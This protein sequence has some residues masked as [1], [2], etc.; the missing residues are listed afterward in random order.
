MKILRMGD[1]HIKPNN[2]EESEA[3]L[4]FVLNQALKNKVDRLEILGDLWDTHSM[5]RLEVTQFW[6][7]WF[8]ILSKQEFKTVVLVGNHDISGSYS[9]DYSA[10][11][12]FLP[13]ENSNFKI[14]HEPYL[15][16]VCGY[17]PYI[18]SN[19]KFVEEANKL[20]KAGAKV[21]VSHTSYE[22]AVYDNGS[23]IDN[24]V[25]PNNLSPDF[26]HLISGHIHTGL[27]LGRVW[28]TGSPR[29]LTKS[30]ANK[31]KGIWLANHNRD[32]GAIE[33][34]EFISTAG[35]CTPIIS[36]KWKEGERKPEIPSNAKVDIELVGSSDWVMKTKKELIGTVSI[37]SKITDTKKSKERKSGNSLHEFLTKHYSVNPDKRQKLIKY[38]ERLNLVA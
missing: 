14:V 17:L 18:H 31:N 25:V 23:S 33:S 34:K 13:L 4:G 35:V 21:L 10:L 9:S 26:L 2:I 19:E 16:E 1:P 20:A 15:Y 5:V 36:L 24:G 29:W 12:P 27:E 30:C 28:Y 6:D 38:L 37:S 32:T 11:H 3:L 8:K 22:G 7:R